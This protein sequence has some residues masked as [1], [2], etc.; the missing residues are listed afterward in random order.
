MYH[1]VACAYWGPQ[2][3]NQRGSGVEVG[4]HVAMLQGFY[5]ARADE[6]RV[7]VFKLMA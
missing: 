1:V 3:C 6:F 7:E 2:S 5:E 4:A